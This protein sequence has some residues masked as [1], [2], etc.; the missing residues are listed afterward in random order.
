L[1]C[2]DSLKLGWKNR[3]QKQ[4]LQVTVMEMH[5]EKPF[6]ILKRLKDESVFLHKSTTLL[7][8][9]LEDKN[10]INGIS[11]EA[12]FA[13]F[14]LTLERYC[15]ALRF[16]LDAWKDLYRVQPEILGKV[17]KKYG[18]SSPWRYIWSFEPNA[19]KT[20]SIDQ[21]FLRTTYMRFQRFL[22]KSMKSMKRK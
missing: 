13:I 3:V 14:L 15:L 16:F 19:E 2:F 9:L 1:S 22:W 18:H 4:H 21:E 5:E 7:L 11:S 17:Y 8:G 6:H 20:S 12:L 10:V